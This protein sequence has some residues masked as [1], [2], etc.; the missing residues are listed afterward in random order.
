MDFVSYLLLIL[1]AITALIA[2]ATAFAAA[3]HV[4][5]YILK[6]WNIHVRLPDPVAYLPVHSIKQGEPLSLC[7]HTHKPAVVEIF[8]LGSSLKKLDI[9]EH[10]NPS[11]MSNA[12]TPWKGL[13][14][15]TNCTLSTEGWGK[16]LFFA[17]ISHQHK[18]E[19]AFR[20]PF[21]IRSNKPERL[22]VVSSS[23]TWQAYNDFG[24]KSFYKDFI[25]PYPLKLILKLFQF[26][27][28]RFKIGSRHYFPITPLA[29]AR[30]NSRID[31]DL[32]DLEGKRKKSFSH[33]IRGEWNLIRFLEDKGISYNLITDRDFAF[34]G[35]ETAQGF[36]FNTHSEYWSQEMMGRLSQSMQAGTKI[37]FLSGNNLYREVQFLENALAVIKEETDALEISG[38]IGAAYNALGYLTSSGYRVEQPDHWIFK[39]LKLNQ[40]DEIGAGNNSMRSKSAKFSRHNYGDE[41]EIS[42]GAYGASGYE[43]DKLTAASAGFIVLAMGTNKE[44]PA[45]MTFKELENGGW[46][47]NAGSV[48]FTQSLADDKILQGMLH[49][50]IDN[51]QN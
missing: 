10:I 9:S 12:F 30:P 27:N 40:G 46:L 23:N 1:L 3:Q 42:S 51:I 32:K 22:W 49:N 15:K 36:I 39:G 44:G 38:L 24:G 50:L 20:V 19:S 21:I 47:F 5:L 26:L 17:R 2:F 4:Y 29:F 18:P 25:T 45:C 6:K 33:L 31:R 7:I 43:T 34:N 48:S 16:G 8:H 35:S 14:W 11:V 28:W 13:D 41:I 37:L